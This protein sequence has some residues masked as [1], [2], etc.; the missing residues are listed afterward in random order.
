VRTISLRVIAEYIYKTRQPFGNWD[1]CS[2]VKKSNKPSENKVLENEDYC[3]Q[4]NTLVPRAFVYALP[5][6]DFGLAFAACF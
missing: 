2:R 1:T 6:L 4:L 3:R 5:N